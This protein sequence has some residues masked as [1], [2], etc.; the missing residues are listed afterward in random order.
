MTT[1][2]IVFY[3]WIPNVVGT[4][5]DSD[6]RNWQVCITVEKKKRAGKRI[7]VS[8]ILPLFCFLK[9]KIQNF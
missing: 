3:E 8:R 5:M 7:C 4:S 9:L 1:K 2:F 6:L